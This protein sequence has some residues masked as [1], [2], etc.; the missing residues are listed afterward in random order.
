MI[1]E[2][3]GK[4]EKKQPDA[5]EADNRVQLFRQRLQL[6]Q[7]KEAERGIESANAGLSVSWQDLSV[8]GKGG[9]SN[10]VYGDTVGSVLLGPL[11]KLRSSVLP[12]AAREEEGSAK[13]I[14]DPSLKQGE[15]FILHNFNGVLKRGEM[16]LVLAYTGVDGKVMYGNA[17]YKDMKA[18]KGQ[19]IHVEDE[20]VHFPNLQVGKTIDFALAN[21]TPSEA[22][23]PL[24]N[25][26]SAV[27]SASEYNEES[28]QAL[29]QVFGL[30]HTHE[31]KVGDAYVRGVSGGERKR[32]SIVE[33]L[34]NRASV[35]TMSRPSRGLDANAALEFVKVMRALADVQKNTI[36]LSLYQAGNGIFNQFDKVLVIAEGQVIFFGPRALAQGYMTDLGFEM[37]DGANVADFL[38][39]ATSPAERRFRPGYEGSA[40]K[41]VAEFVKRYQESDI[42]R[43]VAAELRQ[44][45]DDQSTLARE[46][47][48]TL[49][50]TQF[51]KHRFAFKS[52]PQ[53]VSLFRQTWAALTREYFQRLQDRPTLF[54]RYISLIVNAFIVGSALYQVPDN[55][56]GLF[57]SA[58]TVFLTVVVPMILNLAETT[59]AFTGRPI[60]NKHRNYSL[61]RPGA[62]IV[63]QTIADVATNLL[64]I[65]I[66]TIII[67]FLVG[68][69]SEAGPFFVYVLFVYIVALVASSFFRLVGSSFPTFEDASKLSG[70][71]FNLFASY[72][73]YFIPQR[74]MKVW[75]GWTRWFNPLFY[76]VSSMISTQ[77]SGRVYECAPEKLVP[78]GPG[79]ENGENQACA[80]VGA[81]VGTTTVVGDSYLDIELNFTPSN[82]WKYFAALLGLWLAFVVL[83]I[84]A[85]ELMPLGGSSQ[86][87]L[88]FNRDSSSRIATKSSDDDKTQEEKES[89]DSENT[90]TRDL[91]SSQSIFTWKHLSYEVQAGGKTTLMDVLAQRKTEGEITGEVLLDGQPLP[92]SFQ[93]T[94]GYV[95]QLDIRSPQATVREALE[96]SALLRQPRSY[97]D[98]QKLAY[99]D[100]IIDLLDLHDVENALVGEPGAGLSVEQRKRLT[101]GVELV[102]RPRLVFADEP[103]SGLDGQSAYIIVRFLRR[104]AAA[105]QAVVVVIHQPSA[106]L[107]AEFDSLLLLRSGGQTVYF[108][109]RANMPQYFAQQG[110]EFPRD[111]NPAEYMIDIVSG[112]LGRGQDW[113]QKWLESKQHDEVVEEL[114][115]LKQQNA[116]NASTSEDDKYEFASTNLAQL[117][118]VLRRANIQIYRNSPYVMN[119]V[120]LHIG[121]G[122]LNGLSFLQLGQTLTDMQSRVFTIFGFIFVAPGVI[123]QLQPKF[124]KNRDLYEQREKK[125]KFYTWAAFI[126]SE[127]VAEIPYLLVCGLL[128]F[129]CWWPVVGFSMRPGVAGPAYLEVVLYE[130]LSTGLGQAIA[131]YA[132]NATVAGLI[133]PLVIGTLVLFNGAFIP[134]E[135]IQ[136][137]WRYWFY[138]LDPFRYLMGAFIVFGIWDEPVRRSGE[139]VARVIPPSGVSCGDYFNNFLSQAPGY[140]VDPNATDVCEYCPFSEGSQFL[141]TLNYPRYVY[142]WRDICLTFLF[143][144]AMY[145][146]VFLFMS[147]RTKKTKTAK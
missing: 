14:N 105:G 23:R 88:V 56:N 74:K 91:T 81:G 87:F 119:K 32:V 137:F 31:T 133:N 65:A 46:V 142:G 95:E 58:G 103:T 60:L 4:N 90:G 54:A 108:G 63:A 80:A 123:A 97:S 72:A 1:S 39:A 144:L 18:M 21:N 118:I 115:R 57:L 101:I 139:E 78:A 143:A 104:L 145:A 77:I 62:F 129:V 102:A 110:F 53:I 66:S 5:Q 7:Q 48:D 76:A 127:I 128:Y 98:A 96:F 85:V 82:T 35:L 107:F 100:T 22:A 84:L 52:Q 8:R 51:N 135:Q 124:I 19:I 59:S 83:N 89:S 25:D 126:F 10:V 131:S 20:E 12:S 42:C 70:F 47:S 30:Q 24:T 28:K 15:R 114:E 113:S 41:T 69:K 44:H 16:M 138:Y 13:A 141:T 9:D 43:Q 147:L 67:Y 130:L 73:G 109:Q 17:E 75:I 3:H 111:V 64:P 6:A 71:S 106:A 50:L 99:V 79:Y 45:L 68:F 38:T 11:N 132:P 61:Y 117:R 121:T 37:L 33:A 122:L 29:L 36:A 86:G 49:A 112:D 34:T 136:A 134:Y 2:D 120:A 92:I 125:A 94:T 146:S 27:V 55:T 140:I 40:P 93:R 26:G 116:G